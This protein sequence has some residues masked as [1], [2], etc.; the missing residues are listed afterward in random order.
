MTG[1]NI[2]NKLIALTCTADAIVPTWAFMLIATKLEP[3]A[4][5]IV[6]GD[7]KKLEEE[8]FHEQILNLNIDQYREQRIVIKGCS[9]I[10]VPA[11]AYVELTT[12]LR[13]VVK[14]IMYGE[15]CSTVPI[16]KNK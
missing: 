5:K 9:N 2:K 14:S 7:L 6:F 10:E 16:Y 13:P 15:P 11:S 12:L 8:L 4:K 1:H 3:F